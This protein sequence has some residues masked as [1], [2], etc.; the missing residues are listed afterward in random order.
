MKRVISIFLL[1]AVICFSFCSCGEELQS[2]AGKTD[3]TY[4]IENS[5]ATVTRVPNKT[6]ATNIV[7]PDEYEGMPVTKIAD[8]AA[9]NLEYAVKVTIGKNV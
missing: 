2:L 8:F 5:E 3:L 4:K 9:V 6:T 7:I 1:A